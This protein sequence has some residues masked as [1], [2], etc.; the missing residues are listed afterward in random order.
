MV[1]SRSINSLVSMLSFAVSQF[2]ANPAEWITTLLLF[3][4]LLVTIYFENKRVKL[5]YI[6]DKRGAGRSGFWINATNT[7]TRRSINIIAFGIKTWDGKTKEEE[8]RRVVIGEQLKPQGQ[9]EFTFYDSENGKFIPVE[10]SDIFY[11]YVKDS[12]G[13]IYKKYSSLIIVSLA[14]RFF[15]WMKKL[16]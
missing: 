7:S 13:K 3:L 15:F 4:T 5:T 8:H 6:F 16:M 2:K 14:K 11:V 1:F 10:V 12:T 9:E